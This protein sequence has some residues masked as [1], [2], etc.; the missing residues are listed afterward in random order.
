M[1][2]QVFANGIAKFRFHFDKTY[3]DPGDI[4]KA[5]EWADKLAEKGNVPIGGEDWGVRKAIDKLAS[6][7]IKALLPGVIEWY[8]EKD[9][10]LTVSHSNPGSLGGI[11][12]SKYLGPEIYDFGDHELAMTEFPDLLKRMELFRW[13]YLRGI[14]EAMSRYEE[15]CALGVKPVGIFLLMQVNEL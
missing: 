1:A 13:G 9:A 4:I 2:F 12:G 15:R 5:S 11:V 3:A 10:R 14:F 7:E 6:M 8:C